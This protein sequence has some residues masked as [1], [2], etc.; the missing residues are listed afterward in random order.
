MS[1]RRSFLRGMA[2]LFA[3]ISLPMPSNLLASDKACTCEIELLREVVIENPHDFGHVVQW[4]GRSGTAYAACA[5]AVRDW[6]DLRLREI[7]RREANLTLRLH[8]NRKDTA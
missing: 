6:N 2:G 4:L 3:A 5:V 7:A 8:F 1:D